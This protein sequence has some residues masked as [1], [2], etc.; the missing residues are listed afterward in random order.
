MGRGK[1]M[2]LFTNHGFFSIVKILDSSPDA[3]FL[4]ARRKEHIEAYFNEK[5]IITTDN[6]D[7]RYRIILTRQELFNFYAALPI[8][9]DYTNFK[10]SIKDPA[11]QA[12]AS[13]VW[14][15]GY[16]QLDDREKS[17]STNKT[18]STRVKK[19]DRKSS[20]LRDAGLSV[21]KKGKDNILRIEDWTRE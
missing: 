19:Q 12:F 21:D 13:K 14:L 5:P 4:R 1:I 2:W 11:L 20:E 7:Y 18:K 15:D 16:L 8:D 3:F 10:D 17:I 6:N 9:I